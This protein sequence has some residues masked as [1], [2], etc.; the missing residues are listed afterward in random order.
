MNAPKA[1][2]PLRLSPRKIAPKINAK[3]P[4]SKHS[5]LDVVVLRIL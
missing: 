5:M 3:G 2:T 4:S 1:C